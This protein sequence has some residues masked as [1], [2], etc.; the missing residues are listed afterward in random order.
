MGLRTRLGSL[1][2]RLADRLMRRSV[3]VAELAL[4]A[5]LSAEWERLRADVRARVPHSPAAAGYK[6]YSQF[7]EDGILA[8]IFAC[9]NTGHSPPSCVE[10]GCSDGLE[11]ITLRLLLQ[12]FRGVWFDAS[13]ACVAAIGH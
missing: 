13:S 7:D 12:G 8:A 9:L 10:I 2:D 6:V 1:F 5:Q 3:A 11:N 4:Q